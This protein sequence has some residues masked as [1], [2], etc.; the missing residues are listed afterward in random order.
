MSRIAVAILEDS[1]RFLWDGIGED[2]YPFGSSKKYVCLAVITAGD[3]NDD[4]RKT[5]KKILQ[6]ISSEINGYQTLDD[7][8]WSRNK[9]I[10]S[11]QDLQILRLALINQLIQYYKDQQCLSTKLSNLYSKLKGIFRSKQS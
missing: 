4:R 5:V 2:P 10:Y 7:Y 3:L 6:K 9:V 1:K 8:L 11:Q